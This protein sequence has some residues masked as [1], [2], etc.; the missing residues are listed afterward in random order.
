MANSF[1][2]QNGIIIAQRT[3]TTLLA[4]FPLLAKISTNFGKEPLLFGQTMIVKLVSART[5]GNYST[6]NGYVP[7][8]GAMTDTPVVLNQHIH[9]TYQVNDQEASST[10]E[11]LIQKQADVS[12]YALGRAIYNYLMALVIEANFPNFSVIATPGAMN[13]SALIDVNQVM[14][15]RS[16]PDLNRFAL[17]STAYYA[18]LKKD[19]IVV[20]INQNP[21]AGSAISTG[22]LPDVDGTMVMKTSTIPANGQYLVGMVGIAES[23]AL[24]TTVPSAP[25]KDLPVGGRVTQVM[26]PNSGIMMQ[27]REWYNFDL[28]QTRRTSTL[29]FGGSLG[30]PQTLQRIVTQHA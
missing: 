21:A 4:K 25:P 7:T 27:L 30:N 8:D 14:D 1:G 19:T 23:L 28:G 22:I 3:L 29:M 20:S 18:A 15:D 13:R 5:A 16:V 11:D 12:A 24:A 9:D 6:T 2:T 17:L 26:E 10:N